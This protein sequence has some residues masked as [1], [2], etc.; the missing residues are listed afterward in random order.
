MIIS[1]KAILAF[2]ILSVL[3]VAVHNNYRANAASLPV[4]AVEM[5][6]PV[7]E[8]PAPELPRGYLTNPDTSP[9]AGVMKVAL[10]PA[11]PIRR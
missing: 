4:A 9:L 1:D 11:S 7:R 6:V 3:G 2:G 10:P 5:A 8:G